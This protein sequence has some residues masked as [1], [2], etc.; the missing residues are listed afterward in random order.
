MV[1]IKQQ[2]NIIYVLLDTKHRKYRGSYVVLLST[3]I[4][5]FNG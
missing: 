1:V 3:D 5:Y 2:M 4:V